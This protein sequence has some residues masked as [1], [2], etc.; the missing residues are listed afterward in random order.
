MKNLL[1]TCYKI[2]SVHLHFELVL[3]KNDNTEKNKDKYF[4][5]KRAKLSL[6]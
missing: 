5:T 6:P 3:L 1:E 4:L 2:S